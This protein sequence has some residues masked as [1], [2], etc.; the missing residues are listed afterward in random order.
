MTSPRDLDALMEQFLSL[1]SKEG[2]IST[3]GASAGSNK[4]PCVNK[5]KQKPSVL[6][7][8]RILVILGLVAG[9]LEVRSVLIDRDQVIQIVLDGTLKRRTRL[10]KMLDEIGEMP[11][12]DVLR[13][14]MNRT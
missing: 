13:A 8:Q 5:S 2:D 3:K 1:L 6:T 4:N 12:D 10:D 9:V 7:P 11:F 14:I